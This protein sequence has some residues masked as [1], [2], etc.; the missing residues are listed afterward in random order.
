MKQILMAA[1]DTDLC[2]DTLANLADTPQ[3]K[4]W[5]PED[6]RFCFHDYLKS[7]SLSAHGCFLFDLFCPDKVQIHVY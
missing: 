2:H 5:V 3:A 4:S 7:M 1:F 6:D